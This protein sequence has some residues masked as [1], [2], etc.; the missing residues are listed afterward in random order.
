MCKFIGISR[1]GGD[2]F[3]D[4]TEDPKVGKRAAVGSM[5]LIN[6]EAGFR[7][8]YRQ[9]GYLLSY[10]DEMVATADFMPTTSHVNACAMDA[11]SLTNENFFE[12][13]DKKTASLPRSGGLARSMDVRFREEI[14][15]LATEMDAGRTTER[16]S[17]NSCQT[18]KAEDMEA[19]RAFPV[20][21][22]PQKK[23]GKM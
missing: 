19:A 7:L 2:N 17:E 18:E 8:N 3:K 5:I 15:R 23:A 4:S 22:Q 21:I 11:V 9:A 6:G 12:L 16:L 10:T 20:R 13:L 14:V 1:V